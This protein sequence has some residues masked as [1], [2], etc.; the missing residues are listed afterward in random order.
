VGEREGKGEGKGEEGRESG[1]EGGGERD[2][3]GVMGWMRVAGTAVR[4]LVWGGRE[5][6]GVVKFG[7]DLRY[8]C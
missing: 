5:R 6:P 4:G 3:E 2:G 7:A 8:W 1:G